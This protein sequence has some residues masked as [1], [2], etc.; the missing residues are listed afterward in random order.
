M[1]WTFRGSDL[2]IIFATVMGPI[3][4]VQAQKWLE[5]GHEQERRR[6]HVF[7]V[8]MTTRL[9]DLSVEHVRAINAVPLEF[10]GRGKKLEDVRDAWRR[11]IDHLNRE[12]ADHPSWHQRRADIFFDMLRKMGSC[13]NYKFDSVELQNEFYTPRGM[14]RL[15]S[16]QEAIR[17]GVVKL[18]AGE[19]SLPLAV[20]SMPAD[21]VMAAQW[22]SVLSKLDT[23]LDKK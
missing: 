4:A 17:E 7:Y 16:D 22:K 21:P 8:L 23:W 20:T 1:D 19:S 5:R 14:A 13:L 6:R 10:L 12:P 18:L 9:A 3:L 15:Q 2:A 11:Y